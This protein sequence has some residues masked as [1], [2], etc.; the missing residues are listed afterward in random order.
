[1]RTITSNKM[2]RIH[3]NKLYFDEQ[4]VT[5]TDEMT[6]EERIEYSYIVVPIDGIE[7]TDG[8][9]QAIAA[10]DEFKAAREYRKRE[11][12]K[13]KNKWL[14]GVKSARP[15]YVVETYEV[16]RE[17]TNDEKLVNDTDENGELIERTADYE[18]PTVTETKEYPFIERVPAVAGVEAVLDEEG[19]VITKAVEAIDAYEIRRPTDY[20]TELEWLAEAEAPVLV[21]PGEA[22]G[23]AALKKAKVAAKYT[24]QAESMLAGYEQYERDTFQ[25]QETEAL[26]YKTDSTANVPMITAIANTRGISIETLVDKILA[27]SDRFKVAVGTIMGA[28][29]KELG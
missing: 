5:S 27:K 26:A 16:D 25:I 15:E 29:Q 12:A 4:E 1:M 17:M 10:G 18:Y 24:Q 11:L 13:Q 23:V 20:K 21:E 2:D 22:P 28:K 3:E 7:L 8:Y 6:G 19:N 14:A 9:E